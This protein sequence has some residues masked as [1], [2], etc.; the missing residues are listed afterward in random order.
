MCGL[1]VVR[2]IVS[3]RSTHSF[4]ILVIGNGMPTFG[5]CRLEGFSSA[6]ANVL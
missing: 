2:M 5:I 6:D 4:G 3:P 1:D